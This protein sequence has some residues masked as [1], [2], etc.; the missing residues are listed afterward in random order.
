MQT[1]VRAVRYLAIALIVIGLGLPAGAAAQQGPSV[2]AQDDT[3]RPGQIQVASGAS[4]TWTN[5]GVDTHT[6]TADDGSF[7]SGEINNG[8]TFSFTFDA[9]GS[10][11]YYCQVHGGPG[12][13]GMAGTIVVSG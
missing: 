6:I 13:Q 5:T 1:S 8:D 4:V 11:P 2:A 10:Y 9:P 12:G 7:D 3:F